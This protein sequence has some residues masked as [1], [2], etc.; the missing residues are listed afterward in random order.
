MKICL[1]NPGIQKSSEAPPINLGIL[2]SI[3]ENEGHEVKIIDRL[4][5]QDFEYILNRFS[6]DICGLTGTTPVIS[7][8]YRCSD[9]CRKLGIFTIIGGK[10]SSILPEEALKH[11][12]CVVVGEGEEVILDIIKNRKKGIIQGIPVKN[13]DDVPLPAYHLIDM[14]YYMSHIQRNPMSFASIAPAWYRLGCILTSR[15]CPF[16]CS[17]CH[18]SFRTLPYR[19]SSPS[20]VID[21]IKL[22]KE[23]YKMN[24]LFFVEDNLF[25]NHKR[26]KE[27]C[28]LLKEEKLYEEMVWGA[29]ARVDSINLDILNLVYQFNC[30]QVTF[31]WESGSQRILDILNKRTTVEKNYESIDLCNK[32]G[33]NAS[34]TV[35]IGNPTEI[36]KDLELTKKFI[37]S[38]YITGG[39]GICITTPYPGTKIWEWC[40]Q[41]N[42]IPEN[43]NWD[44]FDFHHVPIKMHN[45]EDKIFEKY[46]TDLVNIAINKFYETFQ[47]RRS[48]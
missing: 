41:T 1:I 20:K 30:K 37:E 46:Y 35:M 45:V 42:R 31:G 22:L 18:N 25:A 36:E 21:E 28:H 38:S 8:S 15:G 48:R 6:P 29:N 26:I 11:S 33:I 2:A 5:G 27:I 9:Y 19:F 40:K 23:K 44:N 17:F 10:H 4:I 43:F 24:A 34:G 12:D 7:D 14:K 32:I 39:I 47:D 3:L 16:N 13:L